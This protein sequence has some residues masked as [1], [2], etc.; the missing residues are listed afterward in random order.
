MKKEMRH[1][2][3]ISGEA[4]IYQHGYKLALEGRYY[5]RD[6]TR[7]K[8]FLPSLAG[9]LTIPDFINRVK[10]DESFARTAVTDLIDLWQANFELR[11]AIGI[12]LLAALWDKLNQ[13]KTRKGFVTFCGDIFFVLAGIKKAK[14]NIKPFSVLNHTDIIKDLLE[15]TDKY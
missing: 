7:V 9:V 13:F 15:E 10:T 6:F 5:E 3:E 2:A 8:I 12:F 11:P 1:P 4:F 14:E